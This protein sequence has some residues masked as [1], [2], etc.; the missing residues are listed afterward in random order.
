MTSRPVRSDDCWGRALLDAR[1]PCAGAPSDAGGIS[2][3]KRRAQDRRRAPRRSPGHAP[4]RKGPHREGSSTPRPE[5]PRTP[6][7][8]TTPRPSAVPRGRLLHHDFRSWVTWCRMAA[9]RQPSSSMRRRGLSPRNQRGAAASARRPE[10]MLVVGTHSGTNE[11]HSLGPVAWIRGMRFRG[12][13]PRC[14]RCRS[15]RSGRNSRADA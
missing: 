8:A 13:L 9:P 1:M 5:A 11:C 2:I 4:T 6:P 12:A 3:R 14:P 10:V 15:T 7:A